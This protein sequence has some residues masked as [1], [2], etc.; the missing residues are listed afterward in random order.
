MNPDRWVATA[1]GAI[2]DQIAFCESLL[3]SCVGDGGYFE[4]VARERLRVIVVPALR[5]L[6]EAFP[7]LSAADAACIECDTWVNSLAWHQWSVHRE[8]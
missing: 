6:S 3:M 7:A 2:D 8:E 4:S 1:K 5:A